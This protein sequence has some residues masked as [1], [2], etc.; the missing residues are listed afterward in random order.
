MKLEILKDNK[1]TQARVGTIMTVP[2]KRGKEWIKKGYAKDLS[3]GAEEPAADPDQMDLMEEIEI[4]L[5]DDS[6]ELD[7]EPKQD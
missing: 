4:I 2:L 5:E 1:S 3:Q 7:Q 6:S